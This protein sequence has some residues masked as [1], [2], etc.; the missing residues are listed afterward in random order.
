MLMVALNVVLDVSHIGAV[1]RGIYL[2]HTV[3]ICI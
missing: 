2:S 3:V 1:S